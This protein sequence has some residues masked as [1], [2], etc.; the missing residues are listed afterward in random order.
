MKVI[1]LQWH[2]TPTLSLGHKI[3]IQGIQ[4]SPGLAEIPHDHFYGPNFIYSGKFSR[5]VSFTWYLFLGYLKFVTVT[6]F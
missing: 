1:Q 3:K 5:I 2:I 6:V 4:S